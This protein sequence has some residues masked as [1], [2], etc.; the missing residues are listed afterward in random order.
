[1]S[2]P[3][4]PGERRGRSL[5][6]WTS[7]YRLVRHGEWSLARALGRKVSASQHLNVDPLRTAQRLWQQ[8]RP[9]GM[10]VPTSGGAVPKLRC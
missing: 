6:S 4:R 9:K 3:L 2:Q 10:L 5:L 1:M 8:T 7:H